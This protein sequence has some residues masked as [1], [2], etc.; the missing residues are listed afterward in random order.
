MEIE[1]KSEHFAR[2]ATSVGSNF[3]LRSNLKVRFFSKSISNVRRIDCDGFRRVSCTLDT[4]TRTSP[5][6]M[7]G[8]EGPAR[9]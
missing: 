8:A 4:Y 1:A 5:R 9:S 2:S 3:M 6:G 7:A